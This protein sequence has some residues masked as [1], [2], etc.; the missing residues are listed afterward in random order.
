[1]SGPCARL[2][3]PAATQ[4]T[5]EAGLAGPPPSPVVSPFLPATSKLLL[6]HQL[7]ATGKCGSPRRL[8]TEPVQTEQRGPRALGRRGVAKS[9]RVPASFV[10]DGRV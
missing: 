8:A 3:S 5:K 6:L 10:R 1:M 4:G 9:E 2:G 7:H